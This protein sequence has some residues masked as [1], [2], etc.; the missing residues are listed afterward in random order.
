MPKAAP[1]NSA[2]LVVDMPN[3]FCHPDGS[4]SRL[5][6]ACEGGMKAVEKAA[7]AVADARA[8]NVPVIFTRHQ[9]R[10]GRVDQV[11]N[12]TSRN[13]DLAAVDSLAA[14]SWDADVIDVFG[15]GSDTL[16]VDKTRYDAF[17]WTS[18]DPLLRGLGI[19]DLV[20]CGVVTNVCV[21]S[22][23]RSGFM[24]DYRIT[25]LADCCAA[26]TGRLHELGLE[27]MGEYEFAT[28][29]T[30]SDGFAF[31]ARADAAA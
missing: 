3:G 22:T 27:V 19:T 1:A 25:L 10:P 9:F 20:V 31:A 5:G 28:V 23:V 17:L 4:F 6:Y 7:L 24:R 13:A 16:Y 15:C 26:R 8:A 29:T 12:P 2:L 11:L 14:G 21:E 30:L 18:L